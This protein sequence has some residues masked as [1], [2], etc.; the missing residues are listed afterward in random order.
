[1]GKVLVRNVFNNKTNTF[2]LPASASVAQSFCDAVL[3]GQV[4]I[5]SPVSESGT[6]V[7]ATALKANVFIGE[8]A[9]GLDKDKTGSAYLTLIVKTTVSE[10][11]IQTALAGKMI[12]GV[13]ADK[14]GVRF[15]S[16]NYVA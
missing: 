16:L 13:K 8:Y 6:D 15:Q 9:S 14:V 7:V 4:Q 10:L 11:D 5:F 3:D 1:M 12:D 2:N